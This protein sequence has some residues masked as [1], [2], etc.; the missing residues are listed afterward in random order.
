MSPRLSSAVIVIVE[1]PFIRRF[2]RS[3]LGKSGHAVMESDTQDALKLSPDSVKLLITNQP[4]V[5][6]HLGHTVPI[7]YLSGTPDW[8]LASRFPNLRILQKPFHAHQLLE[9][10]GAATDSLNIAP[11]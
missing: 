2:V 3:V 8:A 5:F 9:A 11:A 6:E 4:Q 1:D 7:L 10:V